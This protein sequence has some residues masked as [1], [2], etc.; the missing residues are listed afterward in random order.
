MSRWKENKDLL[1]TA[2]VAAKSITP[3]LPWMTLRAY[4]IEILTFWGCGAGHLPHTPQTLLRQGKRGKKY[5]FI[6]GAGQEPATKEHLQ[7]LF[8]KVLEASIPAQIL[9]GQNIALNGRCYF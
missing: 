6:F 9:M 8:W 3:L 1:G 7:D 2:R 4:N 5:S